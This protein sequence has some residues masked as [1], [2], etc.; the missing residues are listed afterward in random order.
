MQ[1]DDAKPRK[2]LLSHGADNVSAG[3]GRFR[4]RA[5]LLRTIGSELISSEVVAVIE[6]V[7]N[8]YDADATQVVIAYTSATADS[9]ELLEIR[10]NG[11]GM[12]RPTLLGPWLE[13]ATDFK[14]TG[15]SEP[16][17]GVRSPKGRRRL[18]SKGV[19]RFAAQ[20]LGNHL[21][22]RTRAQSVATELTAEFD[23]RSYEDASY[24]DEIRIPWKESQ[25][26]HL[27]ASGTHLVISDLRDRWTPD[28]FDRLRVG[29]SRLVSPEAS[30]DF[31]IAL[32]LGGA[33]E[34]VGPALKLDEAMYTMSGSVDGFGKADIH[35]R[36]LNGDEERW[37]RSLFWPAEEEARSGPF[38]F[39]IRAWDLDREPL[40]MY[41][42]AT[43][44]D[45]GLRDF[46]K[47]VRDHSGVALYRDGFRIL[48]YGE[49]GNDWL[50]LDSRRVNNP[51]MRLS[52]NQVI[53]ALQLTADENPQL[54][55]QTNREGLVSNDAYSHLVEVVREL[56][57]YLEIR[58]FSARRSM[59]VEWSKSA[60]ALPD[61]QNEASMNELKVLVKSLGNARSD[62]AIDTR[63]VFK[64][65][66]EF[67][68][69]TADA[70][71]HYSGLAAT[72]K[73]A[74]IVISQ[75][76]HPLRQT[77][78]ELVLA[79][80]ELSA[81]GIS[82]DDVED[83]QI[84][85]K[86]AMQHLKTMEKRLD[87]LDPLTLGGRGRRLSTFNAA[88][89]A[90]EVIEAFRAESQGLGVAIRTDGDPD[91]TVRSNRQILQQAL[92]NLIDN[93]LHFATTHAS[94]NPWVLVEITPDA[95]RVSDSGAGIADE[96][97]D[98]IFEAHF[99][100]RE[101][102]YGLGLTIS[103]DLIKTIGGQLTVVS[104]VPAVFRLTY[105]P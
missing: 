93:A 82:P 44:S 90:S 23:W 97:I 102:A 17:S 98:S 78:S 6:L 53:G 21:I 96:H 27:E 32:V 49:P 11:H 36:D 81:G 83:L 26:N 46:R 48:P 1:N 50:H 76:R 18:G 30:E 3:H 80:D 22:V 91:T 13:P 54:H 9:G 59:D 24:L 43:D 69:S 71:R 65:F 52:N 62:R 15:S 55:D 33:T 87:T 40:R 5:G 47:T 14:S 100:T 99:T 86:T 42:E 8:C 70:V 105:G 103:R 60:A 38:S 85:L 104:G 34:Y 25:A 101:E 29:L 68:N 84:T 7:R 39:S 74:R 88:T 20:R 35:Y 37:H 31:S 45:L 41:L 67:R 89:A 72:G 51:T 28:R 56:L 73:M 64:K 58:R 2:P 57:G 61:L 63:L 16:T 10:D 66:E 4:P 79:T 75:L 77:Q 95:L 92:A 19:G 12:S 94:R